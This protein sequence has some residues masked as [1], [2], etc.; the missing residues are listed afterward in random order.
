MPLTWHSQVVF[1]HISKLG[2]MQ[3]FTVYLFC[4]LSKCGCFL[5]S[6]A[7]GGTSGVEIKKQVFLPGKS[8]GQRSLAGCT[9]WDYKGVR[10]NLATKQQMTVI[11]EYVREKGVQ[12]AFALLGLRLEPTISC[13]L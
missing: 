11:I 4:I 3:S 7:T 12:S 10:H 6:L 2:T 8:H 5:P 13:H 9:T 1:L